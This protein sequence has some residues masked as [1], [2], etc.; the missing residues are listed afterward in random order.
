MAALY[1]D[2]DGFK[3]VNDTFGHAAGDEF[4]RTVA[5]RMR[6]TIREADT[7]ARLSGDEFLVLL[8]GAGLD[9]GPELVAERLLEVIREPCDLGPDVGRALSI[10][11]S[12]GVAFGL[13]QNA[14]QLLADAD[15]ALYVAKA[16][17]KN[18]SVVFESG[19][20]TATQDR[21]RLE[22]DLVD[23]LEDQQLFLVYQ[24]TF[25]LST[26]RTVGVEALLRWRHPM[27]GVIPPDDVHPA[28]RGERADRADRP[29]GAGAGMRSGRQMAPAGP[30]DRD[31][32]E[33]L[34]RTDRR[35]R[36]AG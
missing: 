15:V 27:R 34:G 10:T 17:G 28:R 26:E 36:T 1:V 6:A 8:D 11:A 30:S 19:M 14:E 22:M 18:N 21:L 5:E 2:I 9:S 29:V 24:P 7:A 20:H 32:G 12:I 23:A 13:A 16:S 3:H 35:R 31:L 33:R 4:L 25:D